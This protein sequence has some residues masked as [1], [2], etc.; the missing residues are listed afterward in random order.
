M[1]GF[2]SK[3]DAAVP[4]VYLE[5]LER[6]VGAAKKMYAEGCSYGPCDASQCRCGREDFA[7]ALKDMEAA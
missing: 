2:G 1:A 6:A 3:Y 4:H 7:A 5:A